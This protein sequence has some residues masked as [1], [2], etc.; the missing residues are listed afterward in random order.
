[1]K[2]FKFYKHILIFSLLKKGE[3]FVEE[4]SSIYW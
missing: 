2:Q 4:F 3:R 1:M